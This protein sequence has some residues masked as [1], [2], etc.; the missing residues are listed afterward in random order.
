MPPQT[1]SAELSRPPRRRAREPRGLGAAPGVGSPLVFSPP[2]EGLPRLHDGLGPLRAQQLH[3]PVRIHYQ[4]SPQILDLHPPLPPVSTAA[5]SVVPDDSGQLAFNPG[6][7]LTH[8]RGVGRRGPGPRRIILGLII[9]LDDTA[10]L[11]LGQRRHAACLPQAPGTLGA[12]KDKLPARGVGTAFF[13]GGLLPPG[14]R[15]PVLRGSQGKRLGPAPRRLY[16]RGR[17][18]VDRHSQALGRAPGA[19]DLPVPA[20]PVDRH[21]LD[22][23]ALGALFGVQ[24]RL[25]IPRF[26]AVAGQEG[27]RREQFPVGVQTEVEQRAITIGALLA[28]PASGSTTLRTGSPWS[29]SS[30]SAR[31]RWASATAAPKRARSVSGDTGSGPRSCCRA[32]AQSTSAR[33]WATRCAKRSRSLR[34]AVACRRRVA[35]ASSAS[36][37]HFKAC[38]FHGH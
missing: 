30:R 3:P 37:S 4:S 18:H 36:N 23:R 17:G 19:Q 25:G 34:S 20:T 12:G 33:T 26:V 10:P 32:A 29:G 21:R 2:P 9:I 15:H 31:T 1:C 16:R 14:T 8:G 11:L 27:E 38:F 28:T 7:V 13:G 22:R 6:M 5:P 35:S 24:P